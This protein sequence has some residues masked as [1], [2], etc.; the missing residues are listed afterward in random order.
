MHSSVSYYFL[1][2]R[3][4][5][6]FMMVWAVSACHRYD[7]QG[8]IIRQTPHTVLYSYAIANGMARG[9][10]MT[11][12]LYLAQEQAILKA[13]RDARAALRFFGKHPSRS[14]LQ[15]AG[16]KVENLIGVIEAQKTS[17]HQIMR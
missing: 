9:R 17:S 16:Q 11:K 7:F 15:Q 1:F 14:T 3:V 10:F 4:C 13:D 12:P 5:I 6:V 2:L 8:I